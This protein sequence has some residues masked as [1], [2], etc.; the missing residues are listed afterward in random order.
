MLG[1]RIDGPEDASPLV[2]LNSVGT[3]T[4]MWD[5]CVAALAD[6]FRVVRIDTRGHGGSLPSPR[7]EGVTMADLAQDVTETLDA[8]GVERADFAGVSIGGMTA[9]WLAVHRPARVRRLALVCTSAAPPNADG[10]RRRAQI[11]RREGMTAVLG[12]ADRWLTAGIREREPLLDGTLRAMLA[13]VDAESYAQCCEAIAAFDIVADLPRIAAPALVVSGT[14]DEA[15]PPGH[16]R[17]L[18][19]GL[20]GASFVELNPAAHLPTYEQAGALATLLTEHFAGDP[21]L[22]VGYLER[23]RVLG[24]EHV[25][26]AIAASTPFTAAFQDFITRYAWGGV[27]AR[28][29]IS[30][31]ER[32]LLT[33]ACLVTLGAEHEI[34]M[35]VRGALRNGLTPDEIAEALLHTAVYAGVPRANRAFAVAREVIAADAAHPAD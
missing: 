31:R 4:E 11:V 28:G 21:Q 10:Y 35:H 14:Q 7:T 9:M 32:S 24:D 27:W 23:R 8:L 15:L 19:E 1:Y 34:G 16:G 25:D 17:R 20:A 2:L 22:A 33:L 5:P 26:A 29:T 6:R 30:H 18:A 12:A 13:S 3:T